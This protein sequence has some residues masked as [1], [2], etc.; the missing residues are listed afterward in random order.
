MKIRSPEPANC[1]VISIRRLSTTSRN[2]T[3]RKNEKIDLQ[4]INVSFIFR[5]RTYPR[6]LKGSLLF[7]ADQLAGGVSRILVK[8]KRTREIAIISAADF[9]RL[10]ADLMDGRVELAREAVANGGQS[11]TTRD[12]LALTSSQRVEAI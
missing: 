6:L 4:K 9:V 3:R 1:R 7:P 2:S 8:F 12:V 11:C 10:F 5:R